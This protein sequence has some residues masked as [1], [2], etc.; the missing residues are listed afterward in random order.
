M[1]SSIRFNLWAA[2]KADRYVCAWVDEPQLASWWKNSKLL[3]EKYQN[4]ENQRKIE[5]KILITW[6]PIE[7]N[8]VKGRNDH[9]SNQSSYPIHDEHD[10]TT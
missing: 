9:E 4:E 5:F 2:Y 6:F 1:W 3:I 8:E 7:Y 10:N